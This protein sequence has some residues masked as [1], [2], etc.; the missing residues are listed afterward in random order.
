MIWVIVVDGGGGGE[1][2][3]PL[4]VDDTDPPDPV[5]SIHA[6]PQQQCS[7]SDHPS[8]ELNLMLTH[9]AIRHRH[10]VW[11][12]TLQKSFKLRLN[13]SHKMERIYDAK[14]NVQTLMM[15]ERRFSLSELCKH[16]L[17]H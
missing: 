1:L 12:H 13:L 4:T 16:I 6:I 11:T 17:L 2:A 15:R 10:F 14:F 7:Q 3:A 9:A 8:A 5:I